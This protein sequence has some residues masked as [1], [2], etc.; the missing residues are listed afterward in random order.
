[1]KLLSAILFSIL[2]FAACKDKETA[3]DMNK[4][5]RDTVDYKSTI[6]ETNKVFAAAFI[7]GDSATIVSLYH[8]DAK[9][10]PPNMEKAD[11][12]TI[13]GMVSGM[14]K[15]GITT[16]K[17]DAKEIY[18]GD[19]VV[20]EVGEYEMGD[21]NKTVDKGKYMVVWKKDGDKWKLYRDIWN[22]DNPPPPPP[23]PAKKTK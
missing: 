15:M 22:S 18:K 1:M 2:L 7:K 12:K 13:G 21:G 10:F 14:P 23:P 6:D 8:P 20:T 5:V 19:E 4:E 11:P 3:D 9:I 17:L 16:F